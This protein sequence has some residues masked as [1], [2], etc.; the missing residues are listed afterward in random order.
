M[1]QLKIHTVKFQDGIYIH[2][3]KTDGF[4]MFLGEKIGWGY[5]TPQYHSPELSPEGCELC[6]TEIRAFS[7]GEPD[8]TRKIVDQFWDLEA[9][10]ALEARAGIYA[11]K[12]Q[13]NQ[14]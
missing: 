11:D 10:L 2:T 8:S 3:E 14:I 13:V 1:K 12:Y 5:F 4:W 6:L 9:A 7:E